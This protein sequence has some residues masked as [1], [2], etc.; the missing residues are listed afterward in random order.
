VAEKKAWKHLRKATVA[1]FE[2]PQVMY[3]GGPVRPAPAKKNPAPKFVPGMRVRI[4]AFPDKDVRHGPGWDSDGMNPWLDQI[5]T[6]YR[7][8]LPD[9]SGKAEWW[10][11]EEDNQE[12]VWDARWLTYVDGTP[13]KKAAKAVM[14][15][16]KAVAPPR[17]KYKPNSTGS[18]LGCCGLYGL[19]GWSTYGS[20]HDLD[21]SCLN[22]NYNQ[23]VVLNGSQRAI[24]HDK[25]LDA[26][27]TCLRDGVFNPVHNSLLSFYLWEPKPELSPD[28]PE[29]NWDTHVVVHNKDGYRYVFKKTDTDTY[30]AGY[31]KKQLKV[32]SPEQYRKAK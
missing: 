3:Y 27:F 32:V 12:F 7:E 16:F 2:G 22:P 15:F 11:I 1:D 25:L 14:D 13:V 21:K 31:D 9:Q 20:E 28:R 26:G 6:L 17:P 18:L 23:M 10:R 4:S 8:A 29:F 5:V 30:G 24:W 19:T